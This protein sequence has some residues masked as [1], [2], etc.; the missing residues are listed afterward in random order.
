MS[1]HWEPMEQG[2]SIFSGCK[3]VRSLQTLAW[4]MQTLLQPCSITSYPT[5]CTCRLEGAGPLC[6]C[7]VRQI[8]QAADLLP[9]Q[10]LQQDLVKVRQLQQLHSRVHTRLRA[11]IDQ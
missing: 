6:H 1:W 10:R 7:Q 9:P 5:G 3:C 2:E 4:L 11:A 8:A